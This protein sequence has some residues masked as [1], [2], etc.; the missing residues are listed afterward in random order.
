MN[1]VKIKFLIIQLNFFL[2]IKGSV[3]KYVYFFKSSNLFKWENVS[4]NHSG[5]Q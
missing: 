1:Y 3:K 5:S 4:L 2:I